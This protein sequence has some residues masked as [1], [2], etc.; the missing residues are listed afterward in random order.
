MTGAWWASVVR[1][2]SADRKERGS[3]LRRDAQEEADA[4]GLVVFG[5]NDHLLLIDLDSV[6]AKL[7]FERRLALYQEQTGSELIRSYTKLETVSKSGKWHVYLKLRRGLTALERIGLQAVLGSDSLRE[8]FSAIRV[9]IDNDR[10]SVLFETPAE[11]DRVRRWL[12]EA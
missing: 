3:D 11:A 6:A 8:L 4:L 5:P 12:S 10:P 9:E 7:E 1:F 2:F